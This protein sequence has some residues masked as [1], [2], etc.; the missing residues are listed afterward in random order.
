MENADTKRN[1]PTEHLDDV[2]RVSLNEERSPDHS[3]RAA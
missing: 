2:Q 3:R 1:A